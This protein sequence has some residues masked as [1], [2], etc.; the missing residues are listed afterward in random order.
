[1]R[2]RRRLAFVGLLAALSLTSV[3][4]PNALA[5]Q[6]PPAPAFTYATMSDGV[7]IALSVSLPAGY[8]PGTRW[9]TLFMMDGY[10][11]A[12]GPVDPAEYGNHYVTI[13]ASIRGTGCSGGRFDLFD[14]RSA[15][16]GREIIDGWIPAQPWSDG[17][18]GIIGHSYPGLTGFFVAETNPQHLRATAVS[19][20]IDDLYRGITYIGGIPDTGFPLVWTGIARPYAEQSGNLGRYAK[21]DPVC[22]ADIATRPAPNALDDPFINGLASR[23]D[24]T[25]WAAHS[26][27]T[28]IAGITK[29][30]H[31][32]QQYQD[33]QT[34]PRGGTV[35]WQHIP[36]GVPKRLVLTNGVHATH[37]ALHADDVAWLDCWILRHGRQCPGDIA[38]PARRVQV[39]FETTGS[40]N[41]PDKDHVNPPFVSSDW[42][43]PQT[44][45][46]RDFLHGDGTVS[47]AAPTK[48][49]A[50][51]TYVAPPEG[52]QGYAS[53][54]G[55]ADALGDPFEALVDNAWSKDYG[56]ADSSSGPDELTW[57]R[58]FDSQTTIAGPIEADLWLKS[59]AP[60]T[61]VFVQ[62][63]DVDANGN[64]QYLQRGV[65][66]ASYRA[67]DQL[68]SERVTTGPFKDTIYRP[69]HPFTN[70]A[71]LTPEQAVPLH[72][73]VFPV[74][75]VF[76]PGHRL[77]VQV[78][79][80]P[81]IDELYSYDSA[82][83]AAVNTILSDP[84]HPSSLLLPV[85]PA[86]PPIAVTA[87]ACGAQTG[88]RCV[89]PLLG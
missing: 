14:R 6:A 40:G 48:A 34:G 42:P 85:L 61:D 47:T 18:V 13:H 79:S 20:L 88:I 3:A 25:W 70:A 69:Y 84:A 38:D 63:L 30:I 12:A 24:S 64:E 41:N 75:H 77:V 31:I 67:V 26:L 65:L 23:E 74:G 53:G 4:L 68:R 55:A 10:E 7:R 9:P 22:A 28:Y 27:I 83:P 44:A 80:P 62:L 89:K 39:H 58:R 81:F 73:E 37:Y 19:G 82:Q 1:M 45:W 72:I 16:D 86:T 36:A 57:T 54:A 66:R 21:G 71:L 17:D 15:D 59:S 8:Q 35:L 43:L 5:T 32:T 46:Q 11:G 78:Y 76:R 2:N 87:P 60:D 49:E 56:P 33:E 52:R 50:A 51:R 29:P